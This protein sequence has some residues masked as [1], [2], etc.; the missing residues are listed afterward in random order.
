MKIK[1]TFLAIAIAIFM[2][3]SL[4]FTT[5]ESFAY[6]ASSINGANNSSQTALVT[7]GTWTQIYIWNTSDVYVIGDL[8]TNNGTTY[9]AKKNNPTKEPGVS[10]GWKSEWTAL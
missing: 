3:F 8:V 6:W 2:V 10:G 7:I 1:K 9:R 4:S 5:S